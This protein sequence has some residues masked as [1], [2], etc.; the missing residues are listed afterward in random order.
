MGLE[1]KVKI[2]GAIASPKMV[3]T[4][5]NKLCVAKQNVKSDGDT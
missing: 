4:S 3:K 5:T 2:L 1:S